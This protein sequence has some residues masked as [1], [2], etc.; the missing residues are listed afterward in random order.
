MKKLKINSV[1]VI[2]QIISRDALVEKQSSKKLNTKLVALIA[3]AIQTYSMEIRSNFIGKSV[4]VRIAGL[5]G[6]KG[7]FELKKV[8]IDY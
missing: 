8:V 5:L 3:E 7:D 4:A 1:N 6:P 2:R